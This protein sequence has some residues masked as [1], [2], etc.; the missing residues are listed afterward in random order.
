MS[1]QENTDKEIWV[2]RT[3]RAGG[4]DETMKRCARCARPEVGHDVPAKDHPFELPMVCARPDCGEAEFRIHGYCSVECGR[5]HEIEQDCA[6]AE[7]ERDE[8]RA[9]LAAERE[10]REKAEA[11]KESMRQA[12]AMLME[13]AEIEQ[14][15]RKKAEA[16]A[17]CY[18]ETLERL[19]AMPWAPTCPD[20]HAPENCGCVGCIARAALAQGGKA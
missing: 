11:E 7:H 12:G 8:A 16:E 10:R 5:L 15:R 13:H 14:E 9:L 18:R 4:R 1:A 2:H 6:E 17:R 20:G 19:A 3:R